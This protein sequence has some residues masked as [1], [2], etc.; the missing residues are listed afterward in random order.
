MAHPPCDMWPPVAPE[1]VARLSRASLVGTIGPNLNC[2]AGLSS[3]SLFS[4]F[5][6]SLLFRARGD[7]ALP[8]PAPP[9][10]SFFR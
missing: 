2:S 5:L 3:S 6:L 1:Q 8:L 10:V 7:P 9:L 4:L